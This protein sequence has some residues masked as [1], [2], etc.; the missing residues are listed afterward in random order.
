KTY[1]FGITGVHVASDKSKSLTLRVEPADDAEVGQYR[2]GIKAVTEDGALSSAGQVTITLEKKET[3]KKVGGVNIVTSYP[4]LRG[5]TDGKFEFSLE[6]ANK[7]DKDSVFNLTSQGPENWDINFKPAY[8]D[9]LISSVRLK[10]GQSQTVAV[11]VKP[12]PWADPGQYPVLVKVSSPDAKGEALLNVVLTGTYRMEIGTA[13]G[14]LSLEAMRGNDANISFFVKNTGSA[15]LTNVQF[16]SFKP[17]NWTVT[18]NPEKLDTLGVDELKQVEVII[19]PSEK[20]LVGDYSVG[21]SAEAGKASKTLEFRTTVKAATAW[22]WIG[23]GIIILVMAGLVA[24]FI[25]LGRR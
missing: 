17:E 11:E 3:E 13:T 7:L 20:A 16:L 12:F 15:S 23:I 22:G 14:L 18:F 21:I 6:V 10:A 24:L 1:S 25:R 19:T 8:E 9:K 4:V 5:P 2:I